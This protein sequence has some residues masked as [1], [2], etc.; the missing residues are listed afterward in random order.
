[1]VR[2]SAS[3]K[4][5]TLPFNDFQ[6]LLNSPAM[7]LAKQ[8]TKS[9]SPSETHLSSTSFSKTVLVIVSFHSQLRLK[10]W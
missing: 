8:F 9:Y 5:K 1:M 6:I 3:I 7:Q 2:Y 4:K 10:L